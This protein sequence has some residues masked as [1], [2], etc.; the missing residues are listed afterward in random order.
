[1]GVP[2]PTWAQGRRWRAWRYS[3]SPPPDRNDGYVYR[4]SRDGRVDI[5]S[6]GTVRILTYSVNSEFRCIS[7]DEALRFVNAYARATGGW[8]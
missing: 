6:N 7:L 5:S 2:M 1:M 8:L 4:D 3:P